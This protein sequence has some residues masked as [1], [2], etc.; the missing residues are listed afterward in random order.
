MTARTFTFQVAA[1]NPTVP[2]WVTSAISNGW[3]VGTWARISGPTPD[4]GL[5]AT[6][7]CFDVRDPS[8]GLNAASFDTATLQSWNGAVLAKGHRTY[9]TMIAGPSAEH[10]G[11]GG[12]DLYLFD[13]GTRR[14]E[15]MVGMNTSGLVSAAGDGS[16]NPYGEFNNGGVVSNHSGRWWFYDSHRN[17]FSTP[18]GAGDPSSGSDQYAR[19]VGHGLNLAGYDASGFSTSLWRRFPSLD[20]INVTGTQG[21]SGAWSGEMQ[22][23]NQINGCTWDESRKCVWLVGTGGVYETNS[24]FFRYN[25]VTNDWQ[26]YKFWY[27]P[28]NGIAG[29]IDPVRDILVLLSSGVPGSVACLQ[30]ADPTRRTNGTGYYSSGWVVNKTGTLPTGFTTQGWEWSDALQGFLQFDISSNGQSVY[31]A[32]YVSGGLSPFPTNLNNTPC[33]YTLNWSVLTSAQ[34]TVTPPSKSYTYSRFR[35]AKWGTQEV[36]FWL[37]STSDPVYAFRVN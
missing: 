7:V 3:Q 16:A 11:Y 10:N 34:N 9:G 28:T 32:K 25:S 22:G 6:N 12:C 24:Y 33:D 35:I 30:L 14:W 37:S 15:R 20:T 27:G 8:N 23:I 31:L 36:A 4:R 29:A 1:A 2:A 5:S 26:R 21:G 18:K 13:L 17:E 19:K